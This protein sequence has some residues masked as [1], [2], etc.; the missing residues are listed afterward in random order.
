MFKKEMPEDVR[1]FYTGMSSRDAWVCVGFFALVLSALFLLSGGFPRSPLLVVHP[2]EIISLPAVLFANFFHLN[3]AHLISNL[4]VFIPFGFWVFRQEGTRGLASLLIGM[5]VSGALVW[6]V[7]PPGSVSAGF[8]G[9]VFAC[10]GILLIRSLRTSV[11]QTVILVLVIG[12]LL[13]TDFFETIRPTAYARQN[14]I[15]WLAHLGGLLGGMGAQIRSLH[16][17]L[18]MLYKQ[19]KVSEEEFIVIATRIHTDTAAESGGSAAAAPV[20]RA[21]DASTDSAS[22][23]HGTPPPEEKH[24]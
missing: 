13:D 19:R 1:A 22:E 3:L 23:A 15:S 11:L 4:A 6:A 9:A 8:S 16:I 21:P 18:E 14:Q 2:R 7:A 17:A 24:E 20:A 10:L 12:V 5:F